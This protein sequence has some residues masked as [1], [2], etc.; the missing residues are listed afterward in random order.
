[1]MIMYSFYVS[2]SLS[3]GDNTSHRPLNPT[4]LN[5]FL[6]YLTFEKSTMHCQSAFHLLLC[7]S[8]ILSS[9]FPHGWGAKCSTNEGAPIVQQTQ[10]GR[11]K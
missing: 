9:R 8:L 5:F 3:K 6:D 1:M 11:W 10:V 7:T 4:T 2:C